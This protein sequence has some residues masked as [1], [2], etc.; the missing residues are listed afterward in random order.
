[1]RAEFER[2]AKV[3][4]GP[5]PA[6]AFRLAPHRQ[7]H[8]EGQPPLNVPDTNKLV[9]SLPM[10]SER[11]SPRPSVDQPNSDLNRKV[12]MP[13]SLDWAKGITQDVRCCFSNSGL[14]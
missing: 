2:E 3:D 11:L 1:M 5:C 4:Q 9:R 8:V 13:R 14:A 12:V 10:L 6:A 7:R